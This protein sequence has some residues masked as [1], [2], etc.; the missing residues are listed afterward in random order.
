M[1]C[2]A[3]KGV[4]QPPKMEAIGKIMKD[5]PVRMPS[6]PGDILV[7]GDLPK[8]VVEQLAGYCH[9]WLYL[10][11]ES[12]PHFMGNAIKSKGSSLKVVPFKPSKD[13][14]DSV[15]DDLVQS[16]RDLP[17]PLMIQCTSA[18]RAA[19][20]FLAWLAREKGYSKGC[21]DVLVK[22]LSLDTVRPEAQQWLESRLPDVGRGA[23]EPL[24]PQSSE[25]RQLFDEESSTFT[26]LV[27]CGETKEAVLIDPVLEQ[28]DRDLK[29]IKDLDLTLRYVVNTH[30]HA[31]HITSGGLIRAELSAVQTMISKASG[32]AADRHIQHG[33]TID[34]GKLSLEA[35]A[36][37]GHTDGCMTFVLK[38][39]GASFAFTGDTLLIRGCGRTDFQQGNARLLH[40][41]VYEQIF[42]LPGDTYICPGHDYKGR[43]VSTVEEEKRFNPRL[44]KSVDEFVA[45][46]DNLNLPNPKKIDV[47]VPGNMM[48][49]V[50]DEPRIDPLAI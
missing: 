20:A 28:K 19:I 47:A 24:V 2:E 10:N 38:T 34:F 45:I 8:E 3:S 25:V 35:R 42:S 46:M 29:L 13:L 39:K 50:Q 11:P 41:N 1:G 48:C 9:G 15:V 40:K 23:V 22:D 17:R 30:C 14:P 7:S 43:C 4:A 12:D 18:N 21:A 6:L 31:D 16:I 33:D 26:Y 37:P 36:T 5:F 27:S 49:G 32:A 44:T